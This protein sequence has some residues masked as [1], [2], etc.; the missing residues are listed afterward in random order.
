[1]TACAIFATL[2]M[3]QV[4]PAPA[5]S[6]GVSVG[7][8]STALRKRNFVEALEL[9]RAALDRSPKDYRLW[10]LSG[11]T[12]SDL[13]KSDLA[14]HAFDHAL[15]LAP[16][17]LPALEGAAQVQ[18][19]LGSEHAKPLL[20]RVLALRP[21]DSTA[22]AMLGVLE[23]RAKSCAQAVQHFERARAMI[24]TQPEALTEFAT[25]LAVL[26]QYDEAIPAF[27][28]V[29]ALD[30]GRQD[31]RYNLAFSQWNV[32]LPSDALVTLQP[33]IDAETSDED[34]LTLAADIHESAGDTEHALELLRK[35]ILA[36][37]AKVD[38]Y[39]LVAGLSYDH[40]S[41][42][43]GI[44]F[45][46]L[47][48]KKLPGEARLYLARGVLYS[49][50]GEFAKA[51]DDFEMA[52]RLNP[53]TSFAGAAEGLV[54]SQEHRSAE[55][56]AAFRKAAKAHPEVALTQFLLAE[57][58]S[59]EDIHE[60][61]P[62]YLE[63]VRAAQLAITLD[64]QMAAA[65]D[66]LAGLYVQNG[67]MQLAI[68][69]SEIALRLDPNDQQAIYHMILALRKTDRKAEVPALLRQLMELRNNEKAE[70]M[71]KNRHQLVEVSERKTNVHS[72]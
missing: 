29:L 50:T 66:L 46:N 54:K 49:Q 59:Q 8:I 45:L 10:T 48:M 58:L 39:L 19:R 62:E 23:Y 60:G 55:A 56:L 24:S 25:C 42:Q 27:Q 44:D 26:R 2:C 63:E 72:P 4:T 47:G 1:M 64:P 36:N 35:A 67:H 15:K 17:Y 5:D 20:L 33:L 9:S 41:S 22:H 40:E 16:N 31:A 52:N 3:A 57:A 71:K 32:N 11:L 61:S 18:Y 53:N 68:S 30:S 69:H 13:G 51:M 6:A 12:Y 70:S 65:H 34:A 21:D 28:R 7:R 37:P 43:V 38:A 14:I